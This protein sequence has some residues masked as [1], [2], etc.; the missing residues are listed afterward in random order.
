MVSTQFLNLRK[1]KKVLANSFQHLQT[2]SV[3]FQI[4]FPIDAI[5]ILIP[6]MCYTSVPVVQSKTF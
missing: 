2:L 1:E 4:S 5:K 6:Q 3:F